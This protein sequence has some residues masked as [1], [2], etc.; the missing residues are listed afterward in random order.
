MPQLIPL[1][2]WHR[3]WVSVFGGAGGDLARK[4]PSR[5]EVYNDLNADLYN[6][7]KVLRDETLRRR[8]CCRLLYS[9]PSR[10][11]FNECLSVIHSSEGEPI[12]RAYAFLYAAAYCYGGKDPSVSTPG[13]FCVR[14][15]RISRSWE[16]AIEHIE[17]VGR[18]FFAVTLENLPWQE[19]LDRYD[20]ADVLFY[21]DPP[22]VLSTRVSPNIYLH[23][24]ENGEHVELATR[25]RSI[26]GLAMLS[27]YR[28]PIYDAILADWRT[29]DIQTYCSISPAKK[30]PPRIETVWMNYGKDGKRLQG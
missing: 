22:Y 19:V 9:P 20:A 12:D 11:H 28:N 14:N 1:I 26:K 10:L 24:M 7:F 16:A 27:G 3:T 25:L 4:P 29:V 17:A 30:K 13:S 6:V 18:R 8:V 2:T 23:D 21:L 5:V 15:V